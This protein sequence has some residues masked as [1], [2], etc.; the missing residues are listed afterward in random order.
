[1]SSSIAL[2]FGPWR[3]SLLL[4]QELVGSPLGWWLASW[5]DHLVWHWGHTWLPV[6]ASCTAARVLNRGLHACEKVLLPSEPPPQHVWEHSESFS[7]SSNITFA[8][9]W[10]AKCSYSQRMSF[11]HTLLCKLRSGIQCLLCVSAIEPDPKAEMNNRLYNCDHKTLW[12][13][14]R[15][16][17]VLKRQKA[18]QCG[19]VLCGCLWEACTS[20]ATWLL[21]W[22]CNLT[23]C[24][25]RPWQFSVWIF[26]MTLI[27]GSIIFIA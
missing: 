3:Q 15:L 21:L 22:G 27:I 16:F 13:K 26:R 5:S 10:L 11:R 2:C 14:H 7:A 17:Y 8:A 24:V 6:P 9:Q 23:L 12:R 19:I 1:M 20:S 18:E 4:S 25:T